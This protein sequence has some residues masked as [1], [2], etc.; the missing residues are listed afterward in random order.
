MSFLPILSAVLLTLVFP[1]FNWAMAAWIALVPFAITVAKASPSGYLGAYFGGLVFYLLSLN[2]VRTCYDSDGI[3]GPWATAWLVTAQVLAPTWSISLGIARLLFHD[4]Q[5]PMSV[6]LACGWGM[7]EYLGRTFS[8]AVSGSRFPFLE[9]AA[10]QTNSLSLIQIADL[11]GS[12][13]VTLLV[14][15]MNGL[16][17]DLAAKPRRW[18][19]SAVGTALLG[20]TLLYGQWRLQEPNGPKHATV[21]LM[22]FAAPTEPGASIPQTIQGADLLLWPESAL[23]HDG[24]T[25]AATVERLKRYAVW[26]QAALLVG[27]DRDTETEK[28]N[29]AAFATPKSYQGIYDKTCL[30]P[31]VE[32]IPPGVFSCLISVGGRTY[33]PGTRW[34]TFVWGNTR[35]GPAICYDGCTAEV[36]WK[37]RDCDL[38]AVCGSEEADSTSS[39]RESMLQIVQLRAVEFRQPVI[40][41]VVGGYSGVVSST[42][43]TVRLCNIDKPTRLQNI[44]IGNRWTVYAAFGYWPYLGF[45]VL[46]FARHLLLKKGMT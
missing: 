45:L 7:A 9:I 34:P 41:N 14:V 5:Y 31:I 44:P 13:L 25:A 43:Q 16:L 39:L 8:H 32:Y 23:G 18:R 28:N 17:W 11:G 27:W 2:W 12:L 4:F 22:P 35:I 30:V 36:F 42:G 38:V 33:H 29:S 24:A 19:T 21:C 20:L 46:G 15:F 1:P 3:S 40:R 37:Y 26:C 10:T 6:S